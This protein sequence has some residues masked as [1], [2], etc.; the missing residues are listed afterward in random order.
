VG[1]PESLLN[2]RGSW[3]RAVPRLDVDLGIVNTHFIVAYLVV[4]AQAP[5][6]QKARLLPKMATGEVRGAFL[7][8]RARGR[9]GRGRHPP[10]RP[11][12]SGESYVLQWT[13]DVLTNA[14]TRSVGGHPGQDRAR[15]PDRLRAT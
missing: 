13:E 15:R 12:S 1:S 14:A 9:L 8:V 4:P 5:P 7:D 2:L 3:W 10:Q 6:E 11:S